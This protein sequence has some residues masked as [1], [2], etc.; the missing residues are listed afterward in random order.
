MQHL[1]LKAKKDQSLIRKH[2][3]VF[4]GAVERREGEMTDGDLVEVYS[5][6]G[7]F[8]GTGHFQ[9]SSIMVRM[10]SFQ[11][12]P[13]NQQFWNQKIDNAYRY[14]QLLGVIRDPQTNCFRLIHGEGDGLPG[15]IVDIYHRTA[16]VQAHSIGMHR[17]RQEI[18]EALKTILGEQLLAIYYKSQTTLPQEMAESIQ[19]EYLWGSRTDDI[20]LENGN[21]F[22]IDWEE[23]Q[24]TGFF[25]DQREN[26]ELLQTYAEG[27]RVL[28]TFCYTGGF[29]IYALKAGAKEVVSVDISGKAMEIVDRNVTLNGFGNDQHTSI[30]ADVL[31]YLRAEDTPEFDVV[32]V[33]PPAY[34]KNI[35]KRHNAIQG[36]KRLNEAAIRKVK[37]GGILF[38]FSCSQVV[39]RQLFYDTVTAAAIETRR[40]VRVMHHLTQPPDH[41]VQMA[42]P[43]GSYLKGLVLEIG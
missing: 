37:K 21:Q 8:L 6:N 2:P 27:N 7:T 36:Y 3:W 24:K 1:Y 33:D 14:R 30:K 34:A 11:K 23:G 39:D 5:K 9:E 29:S 16:V 13:I 10:L 43:E 12:G 15:L 19:N 26:R 17:N 35:R 42:H 31:Q 41:P 40:P 18:A 4:S 20:A 38:T 28:N 32:V 25:L 22:Y